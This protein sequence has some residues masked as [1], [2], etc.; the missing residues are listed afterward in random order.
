MFVKICGITSE[1]DALL[2]VAMGADAVLLIV[3]ALEP[4]EVSRYRKLAEELGMAS[5]VEVHD[6]H[7]LEAALAAGAGIIGVN[8]R[9]LRTFEVDRGRAARLA[10]RIPE[11][12]LGV[13][14]SGIRD[15]ADV[16]SLEAAGFDA[17]LVGEC[18]VTSPD[19]AAAVVALRGGA[20]G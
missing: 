3:A 6:E 18:L 4:D 5:V 14:E 13:A 12:V 20:G 15:R 11:G 17:V 1:E 9:D 10:K 19:P 8:Q 2:A 16:I 7:E